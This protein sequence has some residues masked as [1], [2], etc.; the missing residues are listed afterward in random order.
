M[1]DVKVSVGSP[2]TQYADGFEGVRS[3]WVGS[4]GTTVAV[5]TLQ[6]HAGTRSF[7]VSSAV[8]VKGFVPFTPGTPNTLTA[9][10]KG[11]GTVTPTVQFY[12]SSWSNLGTAPA[13]G[14][15]LSATVWQQWTATYTPPANTGYVQI[16]WGNAS[17]SP[18][19]VDDVAATSGSGTT[20][21]TTDAISL[22]RAGRVL[23]DVNDGNTFTYGYDSTGRLVTAV[24]P[25]HS[26]AYGYVASGGCGASP[27]AGKNTNR[28]SWSDGATVLAS[29]C[30]DTADRLTSTTQAG[31][32]TAP[33]YDTHGNTVS[34]AG[35]TLTYDPADRHMSTTSATAQVSYSRDALDRIVARFVGGLAQNRYS[36]A[37]TS[38]A[39]SATLSPTNVVTEL[40]LGLPGGVML[41]TRATGNVWSY[42]NLHGDVIATAN[43]AGTKTGGPFLTDPF[44][45][46]L[47]GGL[48]DNSAGNMDNAW[49][50]QH[51]RPTE[52]E[53]GIEILIEM[54]ARGYSPMLGRFLELDLFE[55]GASL[56]GYG[57]VNDPIDEWD[58]TGLLN[59]KKWWK[60]HGDGA[61]AGPE[62]LGLHSLL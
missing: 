12:S 33:M 30:Y 23:T 48:P 61:L 47:S 28:T 57:Y 5:S 59:L 56:G 43:Q 42:P 1:D 7:Q 45:N 8:G 34:L 53:A 20:D 21:L 26:Y 41:T 13:S 18:W 38:D 52:H 35:Q 10:F 11:A 39:A 22:S 46:S 36:Y 37:G 4:A 58:L 60:D 49:L 25:G 24:V 27:A 29:Y 16:V 62:P 55:L 32:T 19:Y 15:V 9:W 2:N 51:Q 40:T 50:G 14:M 54:G 31:Y 17:T 44:G 3:V 6:A